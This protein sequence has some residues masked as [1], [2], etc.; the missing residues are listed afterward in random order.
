MDTP[1][2]RRDCEVEKVPDSRVGILLR[3]LPETG[4]YARVLVEGKDSLT[5]MK[6][7]IS[8]SRYRQIYAYVR[9]KLLDS[10][11]AVDWKYGFWLR[12]LP[13]NVKTIAECG[14]EHSMYKVISL[15]QWND[16][17]RI[18]EMLTGSHGSDGK[19]GVIW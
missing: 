14:D 16:R 7:F 19:A 5:F 9:R 4:Q 8:Q 2:A 11:P 12:R 6:E 3:L 1:I 17:H 15:N 10:P 13:N 18:L